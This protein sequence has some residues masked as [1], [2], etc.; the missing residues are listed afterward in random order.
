[1]EENFWGLPLKTLQRLKA[2]LLDLLNQYFYA[3]FKEVFLV[4]NQSKTL[5]LPFGD[6]AFSNFQKQSHVPITEVLA[7]VVCEISEKTYLISVFRLAL[8]LPPH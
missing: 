1:M 7:F 6:H 4:S 2:V 3:Q 5:T 8:H